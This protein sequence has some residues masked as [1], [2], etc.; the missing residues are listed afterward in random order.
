MRRQL[1][2][3]SQTTSASATDDPEARRILT[4]L[5]RTGGNRNRAAQILGMSRVTLWRR[6]A[7]L[8]I[9]QVANPR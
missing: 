6:L 3:E 5:A 8:G 1:Q 4:V 9:Q 7:K 2:C